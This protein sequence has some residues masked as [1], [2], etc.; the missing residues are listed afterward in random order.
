MCA[1]VCT[2]SLWVWQVAGRGFGGVCW[3]WVQRCWQ[4]EAQC[5]SQGPAPSEGGLQLSWRPQ[6]RA[7]VPRCMVTGGGQSWS[8]ESQGGHGLSHTFLVG[9]R[10]AP[11]L[12]VQPTG[13]PGPWRL[14]GPGSPTCDMGQ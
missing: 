4:I 13:D 12:T 5:G 10:P 6:R 1:Y 3:R 11:F 7:C 14:L 9:L 2:C 8:W